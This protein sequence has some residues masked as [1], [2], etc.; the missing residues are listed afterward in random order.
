MLTVKVTVNG[1][2]PCYTQVRQ[3]PGRSGI[4]GNCQFLFNTPLAECNWWVVL[5]DLPETETVICP[6]GNTLYINGEP[7]SVV[8]YDE[9]FLR[10][11]ATIITC[12]PT[13]HPHAIRSQQSLFWYHSY[14]TEDTPPDSELARRGYKDYDELSRSGPEPKTELMSL[15]SSTKTLT[16]GHRQRLDFAYR[17]KER[18][19]DRLH[20]AG[21]GLADFTDKWTMTAPYKYHIAIENG[22][23][24][25]YWTEKLADPFL[26]DCYPFYAGCPNVFD[27]FPRESLTPI[28]ITDF[29]RAAD[30]IEAGMEAGLYERSAEA[31]Q[32]AKN[33]VLNTYNFFPAVCALIAGQTAAASPSLKARP[34]TLKPNAAFRDS[35]PGKGRRLLRRLGQGSLI[36]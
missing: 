3:T 14:I 18:M 36:Q 7:P 2:Y 25:D 15:I 29:E 34:V 10:Q 17:L 5:D 6:P 11:F 21:R 8:R 33:L 9:A 30:V 13:G 35:L 23:F 24:R 27:Y 19:G 32:E 1:I 31:R 20:L 28:D 16:E 26:A 12:Q 22:Q 4:W